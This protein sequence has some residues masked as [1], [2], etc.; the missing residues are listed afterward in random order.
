MEQTQN[1]ISKYLLLGKTITVNTID[2]KAITGKLLSEES[3]WLTIE[4]GIGF[5][6]VVHSVIAS[7]FVNKDQ[8]LLKTPSLDPRALKSLPQTPI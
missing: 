2:G 3:D 7:L 6:F 5:S 1:P 8:K 4:D